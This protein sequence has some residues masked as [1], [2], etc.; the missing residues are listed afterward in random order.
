M[1]AV[2]LF[3]IMALAFG[4]ASCGGSKFKKYNGPEVT[5]IE[6]HKADRKMYL[7]HNAEVLKVYDVS[8]GFTP[9]GHKQFERD[10]KTPEGA[11]RISHKNPRSNY[12]LSLGISYPDE[13]DVAFAKANNKPPGGDIFIHGYTGKAGRRG[14]WT[15]GCIAVTNKEM[16]DIYAM[17]RPG[18]PILI[19]P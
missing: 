8:L 7:L 13:E 3:L 15:A 17:V 19:V 11:Y 10:G 4:L 1:W 12:H 9:V 14:D 6:V 16:E 18:T 5:R 2:R